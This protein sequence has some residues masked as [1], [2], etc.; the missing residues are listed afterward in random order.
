MFG[1]ASKLWHYARVFYN[2][3]IRKQ[4]RV[5][6]MPEDVSIEITNVCNF[7]CAFCPQSDPNHHNIVPKSYIDPETAEAILRK[8]RDGGVRTNVIHWTHDGEPFMNK[9]FHEICAKGLQHGFNNMYFATNGMLCTDD[10]V[11]QLPKKDCKYT[12]TIDYCFDKEFYESVRGTRNSWLSVKN[13]VTNILENDELSHISIELTDISAFGIDD[14]DLVIA[15]RDGLKG[16]F[17]ASNRLKVFTK[18]FHNATGFLPSKKKA[19]GAYNLCPY[20]WTSLSVASNG[21]VVACCRDLQHKT[22]LGNLMQQSLPEIWNGEPM[23]VL[24]RNLIDR[25]PEKSA[26]CQGCDLPYDMD[27]FSWRNIIKTARGRL[28]LLS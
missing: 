11:R 19:S 14:R 6:Y 21:D 17:P 7:K 23:M 27:K 5:A 24:R 25:T 26:A 9:K 4:A 2:W 20:P 18:T 1:S 28:Q 15:N 3:Q 10:R 22:V 16:L 12:F 8:L 13:N